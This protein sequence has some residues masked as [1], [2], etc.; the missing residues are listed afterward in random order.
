M[1]PAGLPTEERLDLHQGLFDADER[2][3]PVGVRV[4]AAAAIL[5][6]S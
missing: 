1:A 4:L 6:F 5:S 3:L 2:A